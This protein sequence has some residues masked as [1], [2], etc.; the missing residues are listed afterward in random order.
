MR[1]GD[2]VALIAGGAGSMGSAVARLFAQEG[3]AVCVADRDGE[4][5]EDVACEIA[6]VGGRSTAVAI[7]VCNAQA[8]DE[9]V[10]TTEKALG[11][12]D[13]MVNLSGSN[14][15]VGFEE[16][17]E[18]MWRS[19]IDVNLTACFIG[20]KSVVPAM[21]RAGRGTILLVGSLAS[22]RQGAGSPAYGVSKAGL[23]ALTRSTA[24]AYARDNIRCVLV[25]PGHVDTNFI[26]GDAEHSPNSW[27]TS[28]D[29]PENYEQ[30]RQATPLGRLCEPEDIAKAFLFAASEEASMI[31]GSM[32]TV[33]G[34][35]GL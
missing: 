21:Q 27:E 29:N 17:T 31:T 20:I 12:L 3:A 15:R 22:I 13:L 18:A 14:V 26:R 2:R 9:A 1:L 30:R 11:L 10:D 8:W 32:I 24:A 5:A 34:G 23:V 7:D 33:D 25:S 35:A 28:I 6:E 16:Q 4:R 19:I